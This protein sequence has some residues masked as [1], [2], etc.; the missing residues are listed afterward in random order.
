MKA[1]KLSS[2]CGILEV[3]LWSFL[4]TPTILLVFYFQWAPLGADS[5]FPWLCANSL[6]CMG[7]VD[8]SMGHIECVCFPPLQVDPCHPCMRIATARG[9]VCNFHFEE[10]IFHFAE[11]QLLKTKSQEMQCCKMHNDSQRYSLCFSCP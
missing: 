7:C 11:E 8:S 3:N 9:G 10:F 6:D 4:L 1:E 5:S 2:S